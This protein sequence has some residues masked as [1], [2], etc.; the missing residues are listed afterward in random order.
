MLVKIA[1]PPRNCPP[2]VADC[3]TSDYYY[4]KLF[5]DPEYKHSQLLQNYWNVLHGEKHVCACI[6]I[7]SSDVSCV[8]GSFLTV[9]MH[10]VVRSPFVCENSSVHREQVHVV[11]RS[12][13]VS[14][15]SSLY[16]YTQRTGEQVHVVVR[17]QL[18]V[19]E[20]SSEHESMYTEN[21]RT[22]ACTGA[23]LGFLKGG[24]F[25]EKHWCWKQGGHGGT[26]P[27]DFLKRGHRGGPCYE[28]N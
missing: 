2:A 19:C 15:N 20:N 5:T 1:P 21:W 25:L 28:E 11:V 26:C 23:D 12:P 16:V 18:V 13:F 4:S 17:S 6:I 7:C 14:E 8:Q 10:V 9:C 27:S 3:H 24:S 22:G